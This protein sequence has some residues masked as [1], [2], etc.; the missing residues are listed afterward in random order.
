MKKLSIQRISSDHNGIKLEINR[1]KTGKSTDMRKLHSLTTKRVKEE[2]KRKLEDIRRQMK[3]KTQNANVIA[4]KAMLRG[5][6]I[7]INAYIKKEKK[8]SSQQL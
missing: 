7:A 3:V 2:V 5:K 1:M 8:I 4:M 6:F